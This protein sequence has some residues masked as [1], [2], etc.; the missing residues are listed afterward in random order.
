MWASY[1]LHQSKER[2]KLI[3]DAKFYHF[4][5]T[6]A[7]KNEPSHSKGKFFQDNEKKKKEEE[8]AKQ[9]PDIK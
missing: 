2:K 4:P 3:Q 5:L 9:G 7:R 1:K 8:E 6:L